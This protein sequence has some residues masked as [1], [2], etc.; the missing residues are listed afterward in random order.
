MAVGGHRNAE[1]GPALFFSLLV[2]AL[3]FLPVFS[4]GAQEGRL[5]KPLAY[6]KTY[7][8]AAAAGLSVTLIPVLMGYVVRGRIRAEHANPLNRAIAAAYRP[9]LALSLRW[10]WWVMLLATVVVLSAILPLSGLESE[11]LPSIDEG[12]LLYMPTALPGMSAGK[13]E[14][15]LQQTDRMIK[16]VPEVAHVF[17]KAGRADTA[18]DPAPLEMFETTITFKPRAQWR[19]GMTMRSSKRNWIGPCRSGTDQPVRL[20]D[21]QPNRHAGDRHQEPDRHQG[22]GLGSRGPAAHRRAHRDGGQNC[23]RGGL[24]GRGPGRRAGA[25]ST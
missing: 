16:T 1:V 15:L 9:L 21:P 8:M 4:L 5:F 3:S 18:T 10:R 24:G 20:S 2:I 6:T 11:F 19:R 22:I 7:C 25:M 17:G 14:Q 12:T 23:A 13:V